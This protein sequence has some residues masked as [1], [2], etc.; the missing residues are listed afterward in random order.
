MATV[1]RSTR[2][3][4]KASDVR[5]SR[6]LA[7]VLHDIAWL[8]PRTVGAAALQ[9]EPIP[10]NALEVMRLLA[11]RPGLSVN[12]VSRQLGVAANNVST[13]ARQLERLGLIDKERDADD[14]R[15][16]RLHLTPKALASRAARER[17]WA[18]ALDIVLSRLG[19][20]DVDALGRALPVLVHLAEALGQADTV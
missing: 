9:A 20:D 3:G 17:S 10:P 4:A 11:R 15:V 16:T 13:A 2:V 1:K 14:G 6:E 19:T 5:M 7:V 12:D 8:L 18:D